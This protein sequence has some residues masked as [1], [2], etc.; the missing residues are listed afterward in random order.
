MVLL[1]DGAPDSARRTRAAA[2]AAREDE[3][4]VGALS[5]PGADEEFLEEICTPGVDMRSVADTSE[6]EQAFGNLAAE[7]SRGTYLKAT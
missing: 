5:C 6:L 2:S 7:L 4:V 3:V 1:T